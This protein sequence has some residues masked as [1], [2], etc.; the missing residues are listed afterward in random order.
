MVSYGNN[1]INTKKK[2][3]K[4]SKTENPRT[5]VRFGEQIF[6]HYCLYFQD[7][8]IQSDN[9]DFREIYVFQ[10]IVMAIFCN[11]KFGVGGNG[12]IYKLVIIGIC[13]N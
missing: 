9:I 12:T 10:H 13:H 3:G 5:V 6:V 1:D 7:N 8:V 2:R 11:D 4:Y